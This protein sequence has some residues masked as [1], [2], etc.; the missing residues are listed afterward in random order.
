MFLLSVML[1]KLMLF[2]EIL[3][4]CL[5]WDMILL[6]V[7]SRLFLRFDRCSMLLGGLGILFFLLLIKWKVVV[8]IGEFIGWD[9]NLLGINL[10]ELVFVL[11]FDVEEIVGLDEFL[12]FIEFWVG[13][14]D[15]SGDVGM[16]EG[17][18]C[19]GCNEVLYVVISLCV[20]YFGDEFMYELLIFLVVFFFDFFLGKGRKLI[21]VF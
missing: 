3:V 19:I 1:L 6:R 2:R 12:D 11:I 16:L 20:L 18:V 5:F 9:I 15:V 7:L 13:V 17:R 21:L 4:V 14:D 8:G 10:V